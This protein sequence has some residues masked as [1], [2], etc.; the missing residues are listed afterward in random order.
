MWPYN[1]HGEDDY[2]KAIKYVENYAASLGAKSRNSI[3]AFERVLSDSSYM[4]LKGH[5]KIT[6]KPYSIRG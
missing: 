5:A 2:Y 6:E 3:F 1:D 4:V